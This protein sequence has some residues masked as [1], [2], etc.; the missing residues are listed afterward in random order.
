MIKN[1]K[2]HQKFFCSKRKIFA[3]VPI[4][5]IIKENFALTKIFPK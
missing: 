1:F 5:C 2:Q 3:A 4:K